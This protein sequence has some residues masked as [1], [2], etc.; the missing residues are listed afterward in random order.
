MRCRYR[1]TELLWQCPHCHEWNTFVEER[2]TPATDNEA[3]IP[4]VARPLDPLPTRLLRVALTGGIATGKSYCLA[5]VRG[6]R[7]ADD[8]RRRAGAPG[9]RARHGRLRARSSRASAP[10][11]SR[12]TA[13][14]T[15]RRSGALVFADADARRA[16]EAI[17]HPVVY[18]AIERW[19]EGLASGRPRR[20]AIADIPLLFETGRE[21]DFDAVIVTHLPGR[22]SRRAGVMR[23]ERPV[24]EP[25]RDRRI[26]QSAADRGEGAGARD[27]VID[28]SG[29]FEETDRAGCARDLDATLAQGRSALSAAVSVFLSSIAI[30]SGPT[31]P[32]TGVSA[33]ATSATR[34]MHV[35]DDRRALRVERRDARAV[36][37][38]RSPTTCS[39]VAER[40]DADVNDGRAR[41]DELAA[42]RTPA[43]RSPRPG[44]PPRAR[45][46]ARSAVFE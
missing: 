4:G 15:A 16:L 38:R 13:R 34:G 2:I 6:A 26:A 29:T 24:A 10:R 20:V 17:V 36:R 42:S 14:S 46:A 5:R 22:D 41:L 18:A 1:S 3:E 7:R 27:Y 23:A 28:T 19:F 12:P 43:G 8:R 37:R 33:P 40:V 32:G 9:R 31:P 39:R 35:A 25:R 45:R 21:H 30:V 11:S 44:C